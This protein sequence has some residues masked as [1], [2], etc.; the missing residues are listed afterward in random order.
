MDGL[1]AH[2]P[3]KKKV[4]AFSTLIWAGTSGDR[5]K[6]IVLGCGLTRHDFYKMTYGAAAFET[7]H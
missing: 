2:C 5:L 4:S 7:L 3:N 6:L 1:R